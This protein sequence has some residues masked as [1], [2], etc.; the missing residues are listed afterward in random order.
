MAVATAVRMPSSTP[1]CRTSN[2]GAFP[3][4]AAS[5]DL[6]SARK[7]PRA[8]VIQS[9][10]WRSLIAKCT[11]SSTSPCCAVSTLRAPPFTRRSPPML[12][13]QMVP[14][15]SSEIPRADRGPGC[16]TACAAPSLTVNTPRVV[17]IQ[18]VPS[19]ATCSIQ[20]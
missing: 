13:I 7:I 9:P 10:P 11:S 3:S 12:P 2:D 19:C 1:N 6:R 18:S 20:T 5:T 17:A 15:S 4:A 14:F 16:H 8:P